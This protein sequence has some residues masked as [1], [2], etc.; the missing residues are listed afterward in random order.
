MKE[1]NKLTDEQLAAELW[2]HLLRSSS[3][4]TRQLLKAN[5]DMEQCVDKD[6][7][8]LREKHGRRHDRY[9]LAWL[10][11]SAAIQAGVC[12]L[13]SEDRPALALDF[14]VNLLLDKGERDPVFSELWALSMNF[15][16][17]AS[18]ELERTELDYVPDRM[19]AL[20]VLYVPA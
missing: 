5:R 4:T 16:G 18:G 8:P 15:E 20:E 7:E 3:R 14:V 1:Q 6:G 9:A 19:A 13:M 12:E 11:I 17:Y 10:S 2:D